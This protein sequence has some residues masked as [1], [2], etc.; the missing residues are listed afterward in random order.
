MISSMRISR[1]SSAV[2]SAWLIAACLSGCV[3]S[4]P[5][6]TLPPGAPL[7]GET[8][9]GETPPGSTQP[10]P[11]PGEAQPP[12]SERPPAQGPRQFRLGPAA[13]A[14][15]TQ[16]HAQAGSGEFGQAAVT[17]E[18]ALRIEP[19]NPL[20][21][22]ELGRVRLGEGNAAQADAMGRKAVALATGD[23]SAQAAGWRL[24]ADSL[25]ARGRDPEA[26]DAEQRAGTLSPH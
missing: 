2:V 5:E 21:W 17:L 4:R 13:T 12:P 10:A 20:L 16:A 23:P 9:P 15:V 6:P 14:L 3:V 25:R 19:D 11:G 18:R 7:P 24:I 26:A 1:S 8:P 22:I